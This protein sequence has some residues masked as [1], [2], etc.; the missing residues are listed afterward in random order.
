MANK[1]AQNP[2]TGSNNPNE[3][4]LNRPNQIFRQESNGQASPQNPHCTNSVN[5]VASASQQG[6][7]PLILRHVFNDQNYFF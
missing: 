2:V 6:S 1:V 3:R 4:N 7:A 5:H